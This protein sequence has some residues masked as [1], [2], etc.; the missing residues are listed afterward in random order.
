M[1]GLGDRVDLGQIRK[2]GDKEKR[3][4]ENHDQL[5]NHK[6]YINHRQS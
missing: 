1:A 5:F 6:D 2:Q 4:L 3:V